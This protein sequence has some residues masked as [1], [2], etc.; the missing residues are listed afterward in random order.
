MPLVGEERARVEA[1]VAKALANR[2]QLP[3][4][5]LAAE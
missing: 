5:K 4:G 2:P 3:A 1:I